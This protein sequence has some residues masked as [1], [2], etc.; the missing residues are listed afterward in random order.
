M[1]LFHAQ[2][3]VVAGSG[4]SITSPAGN[5]PTELTWTK[6]HEARYLEPIDENFIHYAS[7]FSAGTSG[8]VNAIGP[9]VTTS[10]GKLVISDTCIYKSPANP[11]AA[12]FCVE[13]TIDSMVVTGTRQKLGPAIHANSL[14]YYAGTYDCVAQRF[15]LTKDGTVIRTANEVVNTA[16][17]KLYL[18]MTFYGVSLWYK[19]ATGAYQLAFTH[20]EGTSNYYGE[21]ALSVYK[22]SVFSDQSTP[23]TH[24]V[25]SLRGGVS[26]GFGIFN[27]RVVAHEDGSPYFRNGKLLMTGDMAGISTSSINYQTLNAAL[28]EVDIDDWSVEVVGR[29]YFNRLGNTYGGANNH[30]YYLDSTDQ[31]LMTYSKVEVNGNLEENDNYIFL[32]ESRLFGEQIF[33]DIELDEIGFTMTNQYDANPRKIGGTWYV[34]VCSGFG[35]GRARMWTGPSIDNL[36][37]NLLYDDGEFLECAVWARLNEQWFV[38]YCTFGDIKMRSFNPFTWNTQGLLNIPFTV[39]SARIPAYDWF[40]KQSGGNSQYYLM[41][42]DTNELTVEDANENTATYPWAIGRF[43]VWQANEISNGYEFV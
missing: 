6:I 12:W 18:V 25:S 28:L 42:F 11:S 38:L 29:Y 36:T 43:V 30:L 4:G 27:N 37:A 40:V 17:L 10:S 5:D 1:R 21:G 8:L 35:D 20:I 39:T 34:P 2:N 41:G 16:G 19:E 9:T 33:D 13:L 7:N 15:E 24:L 3:R 26:G 22:Y 31:W 32:D 23:A 14:N